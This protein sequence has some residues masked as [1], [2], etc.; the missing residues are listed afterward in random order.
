MQMHKYLIEGS[1]PISG[2]IQPCGNK[3]A[4]LPC[5]AATLLTDEPVVLRNIPDIEDVRVML[6]ILKKMG[7]TIEKTFRPGQAD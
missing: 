5:L 2:K 7:S 1:Y 6:A 3:N 4:A